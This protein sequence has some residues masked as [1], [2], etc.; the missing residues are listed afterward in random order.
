[1]EYTLICT[2]ITGSERIR[3]NGLFIPER[4]EDDIKDLIKFI[5]RE[6]LI[7]INCCM[8]AGKVIWVNN[9]PYQPSLF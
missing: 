5:D 8:S 6:D 3:M 2:T 1:M 7:S 4:S 9:I